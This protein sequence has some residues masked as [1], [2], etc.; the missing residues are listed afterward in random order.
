MTEETVEIV[1]VELPR[2]EKF[3]VPLS[4]TFLAD[5]FRMDTRTVKKRLA[6]LQPVELAAGNQPRYDF[7]QAAAFLTPPKVDEKSLMNWLK[8]LRVQDLPAH[9]APGI[10]QAMLTRQTYDVRARELWHTD[11]VIKL[12]GKVFMGL[13]DRLTLLPET[14]RESCPDFTD[15]HWARTREIVDDIQNQLH[16]DLVAL[17]A[18]SR[19]FSSL[20]DPDAPMEGE[21]LT[22]DE[23]SEFEETE[24]GEE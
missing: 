24:E 1:R 18:N 4:H 7:V 15:T 10:Q 21:G 2:M 17:P 14:L 5:V 8:G 22:L 3:H 23:E 9:L 13:K 11:D 12:L 20:G 19:T 6:G 16:A